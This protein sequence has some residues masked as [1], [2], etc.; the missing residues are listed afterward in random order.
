MNHFNN[1]FNSAIAQQ[2]SSLASNAV[3]RNTYLLLGLTLLFS[4]AVAGITI[5]MNVPP[6]SPWMFLIVMFGLSFLVNASAESAFG[7]VAIFLFTGFIGLYTGPILN[8]I[9]RHV[10]NGSGLIMTAL[11]GTGLIFMSLSSYVLLTKKDM[12]FMTKT[13]MV[14]SIIAIVAMIGAL[15]FQI[16]ALQLT[17]SALFM[18]IAS[19][20]IMW[21]TS[22]IIHGGETNYIRATVS[23]FASLYNLFMSLLSLL[24]AF[25]DE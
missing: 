4:A 13:I 1:N 8:M 10:H 24:L 9:I 23:L 22:N 5:T 20:T 12:S 16:P 14:G 7:L 18:I 25:R 2:Q 6:L 21:E 11:G 3:L 17:C 19:A 15:V